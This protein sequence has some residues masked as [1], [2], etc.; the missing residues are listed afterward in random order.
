MATGY[1]WAVRQVSS[2][3]QVVEVVKG[4]NTCSKVG[5]GARR[6]PSLGF[7]DPE[8]TQA[9]GYLYPRASSLVVVVVGWVAAGLHSQ[10][11]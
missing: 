9:A 7:E 5:A 8:Q 10:W 3:G 1:G 6:T 4:S 11:V 2:V